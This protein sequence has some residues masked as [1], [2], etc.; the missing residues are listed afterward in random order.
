MKAFTIS[1][2]R[3]I[4]LAEILDIEKASFTTPWSV[5]SFLSEIFNPFSISLVALNGES[6]AGYICAF[7]V[8]DE[9]HILN[10]AIREDVRRCGIARAL[11]RC[12]LEELSL[13][14]CSSVYL[15]VRASNNAARRL[16]EGLGFIEAGIRKGYYISPVEDAVIM[17]L[18]F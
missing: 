1:S 3:K 10:L 18:Q 12:A 5:N 9:G 4:H 8:M 7:R 17:Q 13:W 11:I 2:M 6:V 16:Y 14:G 15:E